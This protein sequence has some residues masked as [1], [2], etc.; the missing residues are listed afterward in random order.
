[1]WERN[2]ENGGERECELERERG[3]EINTCTRRESV[4]ER[5]TE[6]CLTHTYRQRERGR[7]REINKRIYRKMKKENQEETD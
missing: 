5:V 4:K 7:G 2:G 1:M 6:K 3:R